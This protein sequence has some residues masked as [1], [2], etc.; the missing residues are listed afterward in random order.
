MSIKKIIMIAGLALVVS[1]TSSIAHAACVDVKQ[2]GN[3]TFEGILTVQI[4]G[5]PPYHGGVKLGDTPEPTYILKPG[6]DQCL[7]PYSRGGISEM[8]ISSRPKSTFVR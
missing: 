4:F 5:G 3:V 2:T 7:D 6:A 8:V 1:V